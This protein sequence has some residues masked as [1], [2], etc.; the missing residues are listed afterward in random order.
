[1]IV[2]FGNGKEKF[3]RVTKLSFIN[4]VVILNFRD[5]SRVFKFSGNIREIIME[6]N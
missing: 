1:M 2:T 3:E 6:G 4:G 5:G